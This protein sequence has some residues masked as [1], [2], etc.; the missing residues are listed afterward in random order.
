MELRRQNWRRVRTSSSAKLRVGFLLMHNFTL[1][2]FATFVDVLRLAADDGDQSRQIRCSWEVMSPHR[3]ITRSSCG[4]EVQATSDLID[5]KAFDYVVVVGGLLHG[6]AESEEVS[7]YLHA[8]AAAGVALIG[9]CTGSFVM[10]RVGLMEGRKCCVSWY[11]YLDFLEEFPDLTPIADRLYVIDGDRITCSGGTGVAD[12]AAR[13]ITERLG[14]AAASK[15][16]QILLVDHIRSD[17]SAQPAPA[18]SAESD[19]IRVSRALLLMEQSLAEPRTIPSIAAELGVGL[20]S[21][22]RIFHERLGSTPQA[23]YLAL[24]LRHAQWMLRNSDAS[25]AMIAAELGFSDSSHFGRS[26]K[27]QF[28]LTPR[29]FRLVARDTAA[30]SRDHEKRAAANLDRR[31]F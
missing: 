23:S 28:G 18:L 16:L 25:G 27:V 2:A 26:F 4:V 20:R 8:A 7:D 15:A 5:P 21:L 17:Q 6:S 12:L 24:R 14:L 31:V 19:D 29:R 3:N 11:H 30:S 13:L 1:T 10:C 9:V 22:E